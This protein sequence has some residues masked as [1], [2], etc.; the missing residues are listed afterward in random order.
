[1]I[2]PTGVIA[3][4]VCE[5]IDLSGNIFRGVSDAKQVNVVQSFKKI[6]RSTVIKDLLLAEQQ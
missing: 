2:D 1:M 6:S 5:G 4:D 3:A